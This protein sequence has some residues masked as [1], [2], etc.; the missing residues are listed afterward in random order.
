[1][2]K[3]VGGDPDETEQRSRAELGRGYNRTDPSPPGSVQDKL[4]R[5]ALTNCNRWWFHIENF[6]DWGMD[7]SS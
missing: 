7:E 3:E 1:M 4:E 6:G 2:V 5:S